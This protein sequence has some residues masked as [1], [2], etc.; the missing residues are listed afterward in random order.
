MKSTFGLQLLNEIDRHVESTAPCV[1]VLPCCAGDGATTAVRELV[2][3]AK[4]AGRKIA[5][6][7]LNGRDP[8]GFNSLA[9]EIQPFDSRNLHL[10]PEAN[11]LVICYRHEGGTAEGTEITLRELKAAIAEMSAKFDL[12]VVDGPPLFSD[13]FSEIIALACDRLYIT[14]RQ[15]KTTQFQLRRVLDRLEG[16]DVKPSGLLFND[17][18]LLVPDFLYRLF[19]RSAKNGAKA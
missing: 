19:F 7:S 17:R 14:V 4:R 1:A 18:R 9:D 15:Q 5:L 3:G 16:L 13:N 2:E 12:I 6:L 11:N 10:D 8:E